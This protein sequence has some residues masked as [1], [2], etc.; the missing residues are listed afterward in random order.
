M[1]KKALLIVDVQNDFC[2]GGALAVPHGD[3]VIKPLNKVV[4]YAKRNG[5]LILASRDWHPAVT[6]HFKNYG[7]IWPVHCVHY[8][9]GAKFHSELIACEAVIVSKGTQQI[10]D[11]YSAFD[12]RTDSIS[13]GG[14]K[15]AAF[16]EINDVS[17][18]YIGGLAT[19]YCVKA[20]AMDATKNGFKTY[21]LLDACRAVDL[22]PSDGDKALK[23]MENAGI[24]VTT[25]Q[26]VLNAR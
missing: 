10:E 8:T 1:S 9:P 17:E 24:V 20:S 25:T 19:D 11:G 26:E 5:W 13:F 6:K 23:E 7:G 18:L 16:L 2:P 4:D 15:L 22:K 12:G 3:E 14:W 21:L